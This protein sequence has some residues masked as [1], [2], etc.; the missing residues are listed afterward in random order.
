[1]KKVILIL[2]LCTLLGTVQAQRKIA[3]K[4]YL[5]GNVT[6]KLKG[7]VVILFSD[8][9]P[10][11][12]LNV[13]NKFKAEGA[14]AISYNSLFI[15]G[16]KY[17]D[18]EF[19]KIMGE[20][21]V[22]GIVHIFVTDVASA[23]YAYSNTTANASAY[24]TMN[25]AAASGSSSTTGG[26]IDYTAAVSLKIEVFNISNQFEKPVGIIIGEAVGSGGIAST[27][28]SISKKIMGRVV[29]GLSKEQAFE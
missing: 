28:R 11:T 12:E 16:V 4:I 15:P 8:A 14:N 29:N 26:S 1:M 2:T 20:N 17:S 3:N 7:T 13:V 24:S 6:N 9:D 5:Y 25:Y 19:S 10:K 18:E 22:Q 21:Q 27:T 23:N